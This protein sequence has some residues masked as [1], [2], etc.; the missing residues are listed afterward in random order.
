MP[1]S[2]ILKIRSLSGLV[3]E[4]SSN[5]ISPCTFLMGNFSNK[6]SKRRT[7]RSQLILNHCVTFFLNLRND[8]YYWNPEDDVSIW[9]SSW[10][11]HKRICNPEDIPRGSG[12]STIQNSIIFSSLCPLFE[13][14]QLAQNMRAKPEEKAFAEFL[15]QIDNGAYLTCD[16]DDDKTRIT[17]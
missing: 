3:L 8:V 10:V 14:S 5:A 11:I 16:L 17:S 4:L 7:V 13:T 9:N 6:N 2:G 12:A 15:Y 1:V